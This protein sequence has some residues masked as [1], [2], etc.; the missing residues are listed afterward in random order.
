MPMFK[1]IVFKYLSLIQSGVI[2]ID[3]GAISHFGNVK[4]GLQAKLTIHRSRFY[5]K[6]ALGGDVG[7]A[8][9]YI[10]GD[11]SCDCLYKLFQ[12]I[13]LNG[14]FLDEHAIN[15]SFFGKLLKKL[16]LFKFGNSI[17]QSKRNI[18]A[19]YDLGNDFFSLFLDESMMYSCAV[20]TDETASLY[21]A[22]IHKIEKICQ[23]LEL[24]SEDRLCEI[25]SGWGSFAIYAAQHYGCH[26]TTTTISNEQYHYVNNRIRALNLEDKITLLNK[27]YRLLGGQFD[28]LVS[29]E[30]IEA[31]GHQHF[32][33]YFD[34]CRRLLKP[35]GLFCLQ[36]ITIKNERFSDYINTVDFINTFI[37]PGGCLPS[38]SVIEELNK[39]N[40]LAICHI[41]E[42]GSHYVSTLQ[43]WL[44]N[45]RLS[46]QTMKAMS[47]DTKFIRTWLYYFHYCIGGFIDGNVNV[48]Q[49]VLKK[50][51]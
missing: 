49:I 18:L 8:E 16:N 35:G 44:D 30:M 3:D 36:A 27:D 12:I 9:S 4:N 5:R 19:H 1:K 20:F 45:F 2:V 28:K 11:W 22:Q 14:R 24:S 7:V 32:P 31:V 43:R 37:F 51:S 40:G 21:Q 47:F 23:K 17:N 42:L 26:V 13:L 6:L 48:A 39:K 25:G 50:E 41:D 46:I 38:L 10:N 29:I 33:T 34:T 15:K